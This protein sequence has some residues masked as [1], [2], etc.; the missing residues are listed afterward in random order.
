MDR[1]RQGGDKAHLKTPFYRGTKT[2]CV[3]FWYHM[4]GKLNPN[5]RGWAGA[6][7]KASLRHLSRSFEAYKPQLCVCQCDSVRWTNRRLDQPTEQQTC[8][9]SGYHLRVRLHSPYYLDNSSGYQYPDILHSEFSKFTTGNFSYK[10][11][12][13]ENMI[14]RHKNTVFF[15]QSVG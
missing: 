7:M 9:C 1:P 4:Y 10:V 13:L 5:A 8:R 14:W 15:H 2:H 11:G 3:S 12:Q 6:S